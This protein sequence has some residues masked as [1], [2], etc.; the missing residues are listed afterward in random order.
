MRDE[1][2]FFLGI[3]L[4]FFVLWVA[5]GG[6][7]RE[8]SFAGPYLNPITTTG[9]SA[10]PYGNPN[11]WNPLNTTIS[12]GPQGVTAYD[13]PLEESKKRGA[14]VLS[15]SLT[16]ISATDPEEEYI[17][18]SVPYGATATSLLGWKLVN[19]TTD[20]GASFPQGTALPSSGRVNALS[21][22][23]LQPGE[24]AIVVTGRSPVGLS[25]RENMCTGYLEDRQNFVPPLS[26]A[27]PTPYEEFQRFYD[28]N[29]QEDYDRCQSYVFTLPHCATET[30]IPADV[31]NS[32]E[33]FIESTLTYNGCVARHR[34][35][36][37]FAGRTWRI[38]LGQKEELWERSRG[39]ILLLDEQNA[40][41][42]AV[43][44]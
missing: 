21:A 9:T 8:I 29:D 6:P 16:G 36:P 42:D 32:C 1:L 28:D 31:P 5:S 13:G 23:T 12:V 11:A 40:V 7:D 2:L 41:V 37:S 38:Y 18:L 39:T 20:E 33:S 17:I 10:Q 25:F 4:L 35:D 26:A 14:V 30:D 27:C 3:L 19:A 22:I 43:S 44:Y 34:N 24:E 15:K